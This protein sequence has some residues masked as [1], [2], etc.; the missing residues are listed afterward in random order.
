MTIIAPVEAGYPSLETIEKFKAMGWITPK[1][2][3]IEP[4]EKVQHREALRRMRAKRIAAGQCIDCCHPSE[5]RRCQ[6]CCDKAKPRKAAYMREYNKREGVAM[7]RKQ[8][9]ARF[10]QKKRLME[11]KTV[12]TP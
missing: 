3:I 8:A 4:A 2:V 1:P 11:S 7:R 12:K 5:K 9:K 6:A 10:E